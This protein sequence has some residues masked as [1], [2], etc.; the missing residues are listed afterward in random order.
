MRYFYII[1][2]FKS[3]HAAMQIEDE[4]NELFLRQVIDGLYERDKD[5]GK[6]D[7]VETGYLDKLIIEEQDYIDICNILNTPMP[8]IFTKRTRK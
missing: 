1:V 4:T 7:S 5:V 8:Q 2:H 6:I 3:G